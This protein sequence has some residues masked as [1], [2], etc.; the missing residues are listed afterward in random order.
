MSKG[1]IALIGMLFLIISIVVTIASLISV[2]LGNGG[3]V[4]NIWTSIMHT[5]DA[6]TITGTNPNN[7]G[8]LAI[9]SIVTLCGLFVT[10][11]LIGIITTGFE[12]KLNA[13]RKGNSNI[14]EYNH[15]LILG[16]NEDVFTIIS[17]LVEANSNHKNNCIVLLAPFDKERMELAISENIENLK[18]TRVICRSRQFTD[19]F[20]LK[21]CSIETCR[22][23]IINENRDFMTVKAIL[24]INDHYKV[25]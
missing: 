2:M 21:R 18:T 23:V 16:F 14:I 12:E 25:A 24:A 6:G 11:I 8:F 5:I 19:S 4:E 17:E 3:I 7:H 10:S 22:S 15:T 20:T 9:M 13:L 1:S